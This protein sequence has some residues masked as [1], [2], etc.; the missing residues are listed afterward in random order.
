M[1]DKKAGYGS[2]GVSDVLTPAVVS[3]VNKR[4]NSS[5]KINPDAVPPEHPLKKRQSNDFVRRS[6][7]DRLLN[8]ED[9]DYAQQIERKR[10]F[11]G[12]PDES[13][14]N[15]AE[16]DEEFVFNHEGMTSEKAAQLLRQWG[17]NELAEDDTPLW[18]IFVSQ[19][20]QPS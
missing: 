9:L 20:W 5:G 7:E 12:I 2:T 15:E 8:K 19:L 10:S 11:Q 17:R 1:S 16:A 4:R 3:A 18:Y 14:G 13:D 6:S